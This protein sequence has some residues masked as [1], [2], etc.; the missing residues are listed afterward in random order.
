[1]YVLKNLNKDANMFLKF[2]ISS[3]LI[4]YRNTWATLAKIILF[5]ILL[6]SS[7]K[8]LFVNFFENS[9]KA[10]RLEPMPCSTK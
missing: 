2:Q 9:I 1:M 5:F 4:K 8:K 6:N 3:V 7:Q 10:T